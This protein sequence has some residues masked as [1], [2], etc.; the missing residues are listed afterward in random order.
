MI[1]AQAHENCSQVVFSQSAVYKQTSAIH[2]D[3][4]WS[5]Q[6]GHDLLATTF[7]YLCL[8]WVIRSAVLQIVK[9]FS[10]LQWTL[11]LICFQSTPT[12][13][14]E[15]GRK[16]L[17]RGFH[18]RYCQGFGDQNV[19]VMTV[20]LLEWSICTT[21][22]NNCHFQ[23]FYSTRRQKLNIMVHK[24]EKWLIV[25]PA[26]HGRQLKQSEIYWFTI[27]IWMVLL[28]IFWRF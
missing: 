20:Q 4:S 25:H 2:N 5:K 28:E 21:T 15:L 8:G 13:V 19:L 23:K 16:Y 14:P 7:I 18:S 3:S 1:M 26:S 24:P 22:S 27:W 12:N 11:S 6:T 17:L 10:T 9:W